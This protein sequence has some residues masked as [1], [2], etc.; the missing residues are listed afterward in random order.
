L[1]DVI[2]QSLDFRQHIL[3]LGLDF[4]LREFTW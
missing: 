2:V 3:G 4:Q 1:Q